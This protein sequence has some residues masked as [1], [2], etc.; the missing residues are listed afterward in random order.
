[1]DLRLPTPP[2][3]HAA[4]RLLA[5]VAG[6]ALLAG[7]GTWTAAASDD[8]PSVRRADRALDS[9]GTRIDTSYFTTPGA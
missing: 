7:A 9:G 6:V 1:M 8:A 5:A 3:P 4:R 2:R